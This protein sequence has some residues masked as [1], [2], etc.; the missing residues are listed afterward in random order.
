MSPARLLAAGSSAVGWSHHSKRHVP[1][2]LS[3]QAQFHQS[4]VR[5]DSPKRP[6]TGHGVAAGTRTELAQVFE[7]MVSGN[8][9]AVFA[10]AGSPMASHSRYAGGASAWQRIQK[11]WEVAN[12]SR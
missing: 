5:T 11:P 6:D 3:Y 2:V 9:V 10:S 7:P 1:A 4:P 8:I 12:R